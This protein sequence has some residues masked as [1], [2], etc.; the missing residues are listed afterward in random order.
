VLCGWH[1]KSFYALDRFVEALDARSSQIVQPPTILAI[2]DFVRLHPKGVIY[3]DEVDKL[4][5]AD[6][7][8][9][10]SSWALSCLGEFISWVDADARLISMGWSKGDVQRFRRG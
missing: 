5:P 2:R 10:Q 3:A 8:V 9:R 4:C 7:E 6:H 1:H